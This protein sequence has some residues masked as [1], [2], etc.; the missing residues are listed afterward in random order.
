MDE[1]GI[2]S[3][4]RSAIRSRFGLDRMVAKGI[5]SR[6]DGGKRDECCELQVV[7]ENRPTNSIWPTGDA[8]YIKV[9]ASRR[10]KGKAMGMKRLWVRRMYATIFWKRTINSSMHSLMCIKAKDLLA[11]EYSQ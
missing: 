6:S 9:P 1:D 2:G 3:V 4:T 8:T 11:M 7:S 5:R 10:F